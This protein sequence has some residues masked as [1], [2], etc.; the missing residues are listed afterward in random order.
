MYQ[1]SRL[2]EQ[3]TADTSIRFSLCYTGSKA[4]LNV[5]NHM[6]RVM[7]V[8]S[9]VVMEECDSC[10]ARWK[11]YRMSFSSPSTLRGVLMDSKMQLL[12]FHDGVG[13]GGI[14]GARDID[15]FVNRIVQ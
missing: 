6:G 11:P 15:S 9:G 12:G 5:E 7:S 14:V 3:E 2:S 1:K 4:V 13:S 8:T 10:E